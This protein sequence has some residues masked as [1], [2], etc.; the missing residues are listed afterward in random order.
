MDGELERLGEQIA[1]EAAHFDA[2]MHRLLTHLREFDQRGGWH[3]QGAMSC[4]HWL[5]WRVGWDL[6][7]ARQRVRVARRLGECPLIDD[8]LRRGEMSYSKARAMGRVATPANEA[9][10]LDSAR[11]M[12]ADHVERLCRKYALVQRDGHPPDRLTDEQR[13][14]VRRRDTEDGMVKIE[15][16]LHPEEAELVWKM[17]DHAAT[18]LTHEGGGDGLGG[19]TGSRE[20]V[21]PRDDARAQTTVADLIGGAFA[22][23]P[24]VGARGDGSAEPWAADLTI[25]A[26]G[27]GGSAEPWAAD[28]ASSGARGDGGSAEPWAADLTSMGA[29]EDGGS[30]EPW[31]ADL[32]SIGARGDGGSAEPWAADLTSIGAREDGGSAEPWAA[33]LTSIGARE[34]GG[35]AEPWAADLTIGARGDGGSG[36]SGRQDDGAGTDILGGRKDHGSAEPSVA[37]TTDISGW[38]EDGSAGSRAAD[39][40]GLDPPQD[41]TIAHGDGSAEPS[42]AEGGGGAGGRSTIAPA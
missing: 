2:A 19:A 36:V 5:S 39:L 8:A 25:G 22:A 21:P 31:A 23:D 41:S 1:E 30:A 7:T 24:G 29:R 34:D 28:L 9:L 15:A 40:G 20:T 6:G 11:L 13:R 4:A 14:Y 42:A 12:T 3:V 27:D 38:Q 33:D 16:I 37:R 26:R 17:L 32:A 10:L 35:S 18:R